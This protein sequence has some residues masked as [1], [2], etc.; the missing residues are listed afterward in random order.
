MFRLGSLWGMTFWD[1]CEHHGV[2]RVAARLG[3]SQ[4]Y[5]RRI[6]RGN[7]RCSL[8]VINACVKEFREFSLT[9]HVLEW[10]RRLTE[11]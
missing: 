9:S 3:L 5:I 11:A 7:R 2:T 8:S 1:L 6:R 10:Q 4:D